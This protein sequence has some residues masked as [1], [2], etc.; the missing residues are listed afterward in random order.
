M[1]AVERPLTV[2]DV[3]AKT[4]RGRNTIC[5]AANTGALR[6]LPRVPG[7]THRF[8]ARDVQAWIEQGMP[9]MPARRGLRRAG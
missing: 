8:L 2:K 6:S 5:D 1:P 9:T 3:Q 7:G 4:G